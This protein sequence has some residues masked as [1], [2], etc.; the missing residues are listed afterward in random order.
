MR[1]A[2]AGTLAAL[3]ILWGAASCAAQTPH[4]DLAPGWTQQ[5]TAR[6]YDA[7]NLYEYM[8][9]NSEGYLL[10]GFV[11]MH[12]VTCMHGED[13]ILIDISEFADADSAYGMFSANRDPRLAGE[14]LGAGGQITPRRAIFTKDRFYAELAANPDKDHTPALRAFSAALEK[15]LPGNNA[16]PAALA[17]FPA[18]GQKSVRLIP[19]SVLGLRL[20][21]R[22][23]VA[24]YEFG[25]AFVVQ[26]SSPEAAAAVMDKLRARFG[27]TGDPL[28]LTDPYLGRLCF[29]HQGAYIVGYANVADGHDPL[30]LS[31]ALAARLP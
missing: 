16:A 6:A 9:G 27:Q 14:A 23:Y 19:E 3:A 10:Y 5:G 28:Q 30:E 12:G 8:D 22:G 25:K 13:S 7:T 26:E 1:A 2:L 18:A 11:A 24:E 21:K 29:I 17:W 20:L 4:C 31:R 15:L